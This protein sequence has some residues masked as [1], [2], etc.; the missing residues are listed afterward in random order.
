[1]KIEKL[2]KKLDL[3]DYIKEFEKFLA[4]KKG[5]F[6]SG[7]RNLH[8]KF[9]QALFEIEFKAPDPLVNLDEVLARTKKQAILRLEEIFYFVKI[10]EY[11][12]YLKSLEAPIILKEWFL[13]IEI[14]KDFEEILK[15][16]EKDGKINLQNS[17]ELFKIE[18]I[19]KQNKLQ[20][21]DTLQ[22]I[23]HSTKMTQFIVDN[24]IHFYNGEESLLVR[25][26]FLQ[27]VDAVVI[28]RSEGGFFYIVPKSIEKL[29]SKEETLKAKKEEILWRYRKKF[30]EVFYKW[31]RFLEF[32]NKEFDRFD[33]YQA[34]VNFARAFDYEFVL[35]SGG[36]EI[37]LESFAH[38]AISNP[39]L[40][41]ISLK[42][43]IMLITGVNAGGK[44]MLLKS[45]LSSVFFSKYLLPFRCNSK[46]TKIGTFK[47]IE[48][49]IDDP[50][51]V[52]NDISTFAGRML[53]FGKLFKKRGS[54]VGVDEVE[55]GTDSDE[56]ASLFRVL[57]EELKKREIT[58]IIT[59]HH[60]RL[61]S[62]MAGDEDVELVAALY[63]E[64][65]ES[66][67]YTFLQG[68]IG[69]SYAFE[70]AR[71]YGIPASV[72]EKAK[73][74]FGE[75]KE[76]LNELI[77]KSTTL[78]AQM[79]NKI[80]E[81]DRKLDGLR[82]REENIKEQK[83]KLEKD[84]QN[85]IYQLEIDYK[86]IKDKVLKALKEVEVA[87]ARR[88]LNEAHKLKSSQKTYKKESKN[89][90]FKVGDKIKYRGKSGIILSKKTKEAMIEID[91]LKI[92]VPLEDLEFDNYSK[93]KIKQK[94]II[95]NNVRV[96]KPKHV[97]LSLKLLGKRVDEAL[98][99]LDEFLSNALVHGFSEV[100]I[101]HGIGTGALSKAITNYLKQHPKV[102]SFEKMKGNMGV[103][104]V[105]L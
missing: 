32:I 44:T 3:E 17:P 98:D 41:S 56:A 74:F 99:E 71:R 18:E 30:S 73:E 59:T 100:E 93:T 55:L 43:P 16:F 83:R 57:L 69:K 68:S 50:Q 42:K 21:K 76:R 79:R 85:R 45:L 49:I 86:N 105:K 70:T 22:R 36:R 53:E 27:A 15:F 95:N 92:R 103:T 90:D 11:F 101:I 96:E 84:F 97:S 102:K 34:R 2:I 4:R 66:P 20:I 28:G 23:L 12:N 25:G 80:K 19:I 91:G 1:V 6:I 104:L 13:K 82:K 37:T 10:I 81:L 38:P 64:V 48:A 75:D 60:K 88:L 5:V 87:K 62:L 89:L 14:P 7:D 54:I 40:V 72:V 78:E 8:F 94:S 58:F 39:V 51:S 29:K 46:K 9:I 24:K 77:E 65:R 63:D 26:G 47:S 61:A 67:T 31:S 52:K 35:P 33:H